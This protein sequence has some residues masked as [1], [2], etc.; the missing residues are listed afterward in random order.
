MSYSDYPQ[1]EC[2]SSLC[3]NKL[4]QTGGLIKI[5]F[6]SSGGWKSNLKVAMDLVP[7]ESSQACRCLP[8][9]CV[10]TW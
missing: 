10:T 6:H 8:S 5:H 9:C 2:L 3:L 4:L 7:S 1:M